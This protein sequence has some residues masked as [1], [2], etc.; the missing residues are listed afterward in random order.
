MYGRLDRLCHRVALALALAGGVV[1]IA[2]MV[3]T[4]LSVTGRALS[5]FGLGQIRGDYELIELGVGFAI[6]CF[7]P[8]TQYARAQARVDL[9]APLMG[10]VGNRIAD[11]LADLVVL[12]IAG[13]LAR[14]LALGLADRRA[15]GDTTFIL[16][17]PVWPA[18]LAGLVAL[19]GLVLVAAFCVW[20]SLRGAPDLAHAAPEGLG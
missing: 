14:Q 12:A 19:I 17:W 2:L 10:R 4:S 5:R 13:V 3:M 18:Y 11:V 15:N 9:F 16:Q 1:L 6:F 8:W 7:L 20:R